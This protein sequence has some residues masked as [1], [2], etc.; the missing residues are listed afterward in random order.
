MIGNPIIR[1]VNCSGEEN[2][3]ICLMS[4]PG[5]SG[6][7]QVF[8]DEFTALLKRLGPNISTFDKKNLGVHIGWV[9]AP[10][11]GPNNSFI[12]TLPLKTSV[13]WNSQELKRAH[14][15]LIQKEKEK[16]ASS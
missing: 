10:M 11:F 1:Y 9:R 15:E 8:W 2:H 13:L 3:G 14:L 5:G 6:M 7:I 12:E 16:Y 4:D